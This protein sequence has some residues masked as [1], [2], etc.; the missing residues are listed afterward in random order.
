MSG[1]YLTMCHQSI[2]NKSEEKLWQDI[3]KEFHFGIFRY[4]GYD[5]RG[6]LT[7]FTSAFVVYSDYY[8]IYVNLSLNRT[9][10]KD[11]PLQN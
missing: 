3:R 2:E 9:E 4:Y 11:L 7:T 1:I 8:H 10:T 6:C 5:S